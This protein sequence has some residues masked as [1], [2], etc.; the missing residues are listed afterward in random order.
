[1]SE[2]PDS[3]MNASAARNFLL[4]GLQIYSECPLIGTTGLLI[5]LLSLSAM[6]DLENSATL[7]LEITDLLQILHK[8]DEAI[9]TATLL[10]QLF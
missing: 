2:S 10:I 7:C 5:T 1:M 4:H 6:P 3:T 9:T 8:A